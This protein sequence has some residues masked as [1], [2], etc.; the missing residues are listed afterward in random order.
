MNDEI[1]KP[2]NV[3]SIQDHF[4][5]ISVRVSASGI[6]GA[7]SGSLIALYR[8]HDS[9]LRTSA[10]TAISCSLVC[11]ACFSFERLAYI[12]ITQYIFDENEDYVDGESLIN[13]HNNKTYNN[14]NLQYYLK[15]YTHMMGGMLGGAYVGGLY[16][17]R[18]LRGAIVFTPIMLLIAV[19]DEAINNNKARLL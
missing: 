14:A 15:L 7:I 13:K 6:L 2:R 10:R 4:D 9:I 16:T 19:T 12:G 5:Y 18:L 1:P 17:G 8:G 11:T 3:M